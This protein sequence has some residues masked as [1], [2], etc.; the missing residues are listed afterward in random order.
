MPGAVDIPRGAGILFTTPSVSELDDLPG[1]GTAG[2]TRTDYHQSASLSSKNFLNGQPIKTK[3]K[4]AHNNNQL[5]DM[6]RNSGQTGQISDLSVFF[7]KLLDIQ[8]LVL[9]QQEAGCG[10]P[11][12]LRADLCSGTVYSSTWSV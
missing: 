8:H 5:A 10:T 2:Q 3:H 1:S 6:V 4:S 12:I 11:K 7:I 9:G